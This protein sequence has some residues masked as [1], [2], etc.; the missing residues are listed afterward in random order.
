MKDHVLEPAQDK[1]EVAVLS[2]RKKILPDR[3][4]RTD[5]NNTGEKRHVPGALA[6]E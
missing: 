4:G 5:R 2:G 6:H 3:E 1:T